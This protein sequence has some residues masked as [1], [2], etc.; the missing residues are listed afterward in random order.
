[1]RETQSGG[2]LAAATVPGSAGGSMTGAGVFAKWD[3]RDNTFS[4][5]RGSYAAVFLNRFFRALGSD[6][7]YGQLAVD[8]RGYWALGR[9]GPVLAVQGV[10]KSVWGGCPFQVLPM[11]GGLNLLRGYYDGRYRDRTMLALQGECRL[12]LGNRFG[13]CGFAGIAQVQKK[14]SLLELHGFHAAGGAGV[15]Y[16]FNRRENL[17]LRLDAGFAGFSGAPAFY[18]TFAEAF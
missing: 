1:M 7:S 15:R 18:L 2:V 10:F 6:Y 17:I 12:P 4:A 5:R 14:V 13:L 3:S 8:G 16:T 11:F 9:R